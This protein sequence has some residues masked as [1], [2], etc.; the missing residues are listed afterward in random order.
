M[1]KKILKWVGIGLGVVVALLLIA[2]GVMYFRGQA[3]FN[4]TYSVQV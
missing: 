4:Q 3:R 1:F 2:A